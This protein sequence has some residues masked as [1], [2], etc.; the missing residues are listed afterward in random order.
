MILGLLLS[1]LAGSLVSLQSIFNSK[2]NERAGS[3]TTTTL[4]LG[5][6]FAA[7]FIIGFLVEGKQL[8]ILE[9]MNLWYWFSGLIGI[10]VVTCVVQGVRL[11]GPTYAIAITLTSQLAI[12][13]LWDTFGWLG[14]E[15]VP[16]TL[17][18]LIGVIVIVA[19][20]FVF[21]LSGE[22]RPKSEKLPKIALNTFQA[23]K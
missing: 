9:N 19:G 6:G 13:L 8:F 20:I 1:I 18:Q 5:L 3:W 15:K 14:I 7:S 10:G 21:K 11:L 17:Q 12:A 16:F 4:V 23:D 22:T 2:V